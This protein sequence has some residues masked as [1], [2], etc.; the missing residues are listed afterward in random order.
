MGGG[1]E[2][3]C[4]AVCLRSLSNA[5]EWVLSQWLGCVG[6]GVPG[7]GLYWRSKVREEGGRL[8]NRCAYLGALGPTSS[9]TAMTVLPGDFAGHTERHV[10]TR[11]E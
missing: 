11:I 9:H 3:K 10:G 4:W 1:A 8:G 2:G 7:R 6:V 5:Q